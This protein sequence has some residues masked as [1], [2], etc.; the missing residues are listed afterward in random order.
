MLERLLTPLNKFLHHQNS[1]G[2]VLFL[3]VVGALIWANSPWQEFY[4]HLWES[5][6]WGSVVKVDT[7]KRVDTSPQTVNLNADLIR[8]LERFR[9][10]L[11]STG[12]C[13]GKGL[14]SDLTLV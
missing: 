13:L 5:A 10:L 1:G 4:H 8:G 14:S 6:F 11:F 2:L 9:P 7:W 12:L 3:S